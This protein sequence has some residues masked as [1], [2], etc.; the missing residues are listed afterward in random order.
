MPT[1]HFDLPL[2]P[3]NIVIEVGICCRR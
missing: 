3:K 1:L 2:S